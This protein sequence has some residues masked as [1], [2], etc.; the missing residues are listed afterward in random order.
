MP[1]PVDCFVQKGFLMKKI[2]II[3]SLSPEKQ[4]AIRRWFCISML[5]S[6]VLL[7]LGTY[8]LLAQLLLYFSLKKD[9]ELTQK[10]IGKYT[11]HFN[12]KELLKKE[13]DELRGRETKVTTYIQQLKNP[14]SHLSYIVELCKDEIRLESVRFQKKDVELVVQCQTDVQARMYAKKLTESA[15][16]SQVKI[17]SLQR[18]DNNK[19]LLCTIKAQVI[20]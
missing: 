11:T 3:T 6:F 20:F 14:H 9:F 4:Y 7:I 5:L 2:N 13:Y 15:L 18:N 17:I 12:S 10:K 8:F 19:Y 16:F 1:P